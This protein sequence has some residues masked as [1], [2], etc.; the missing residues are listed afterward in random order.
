MNKIIYISD[1]LLED[2]IGGGELNDHEL[3]FLLIE[4]GK[5]VIKMRSH[6][7][8]K[9]L[10]NINDFYIIS[11][12]INI[13]NEERNYIQENCNYI[14]YEHDH[15]YLKTRNPAI[16]QN[17]KAPCDQII[18]E[19]FYK[20]AKLILCQSSFHED[21]IKKNIDLINVY[22]LSGNLWSKESL[23]IMR[24][25]SK[26]TKKN[27]YSILNSKINHKN[28]NETVFYCNK[29][30]YPFELISSENYINFLN[31]L[32]QNDRFLFL[33]KTPETLS[34]VVVEARMMNIKVTTNS[35]VGAAYEPWFKLSGDE[36]IDL[37]IKKR[38]D[39]TDV[40]LEV[41]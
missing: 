22:N 12:F 30:G 19:D 26:K 38:S 9:D 7:V 35:S 11:N 13:R 5:D 20:K 29:K 3:C 31:L 21:I 15:K 6:M 34:R 10:L 4:S 18:N 41:V 37:M 25:L 36:L 40:I 39:I 24:S 23:Q 17:Y 14:I 33:P 28:T 2:L 1:F 16:F 27:C 8:R 32:S